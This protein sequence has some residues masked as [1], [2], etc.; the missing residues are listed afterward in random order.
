MYLLPVFVSMIA[1]S[2]V[3]VLTNPS[4][5]N[6]ILHHNTTKPSASAVNINSDCLGGLNG[7]DCAVPGNLEDPDKGNP[8]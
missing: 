1:F 6:H 4:I 5:L 3:Q 2:S 8:A 7:M